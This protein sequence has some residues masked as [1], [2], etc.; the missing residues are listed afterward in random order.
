VTEALAAYLG[1][2]THC[3]HGNPIPGPNGEFEP[4][5]GKLLSRLPLGQNAQILAVEATTTEIFGYLEQRGLLP[6]RRVRVV[7]AAPLQ[8]PL[9]IRVEGVEVALGLLLAEL[10]VVHPVSP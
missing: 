1:H 8:G 9:T 6:G 3:P 5:Q 4:L 7:E 2:P 10:I